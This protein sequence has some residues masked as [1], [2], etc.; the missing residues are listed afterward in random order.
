MSISAVTECVALD[1]YSK[2]LTER[3]AVMKRTIRVA[4]AALSS[5]I[6]CALGMWIILDRATA[7]AQSTRPVPT[8]EVDRS[9]PKIPNG[10]VLGEAASVA[11]D[12]QD[13]VWLLHR[14]A[15]VPVEQKAK[16]A[17]PV[18][19][20][21]ANGNFVQAWGGPGR[22][23]EWPEEE[24]GI[25]VDYK[26]N[27]W[28]GAASQH[29]HDNQVLKFRRNG[30]FLLQIGHSGQSKGNAD[31]E[32]LNRP[33]D[34]FV[35]PKTNEVFIADGYVNRRVIVFDADTGAFKRM[36]GAFGNQPTDLKTQHGNE[37]QGGAPLLNTTDRGPEQFNTVHAARVSNDGLVY[38]SDRGNR[39]VQVF[40]IEGK[41]L[42]QVFIGPECVAPAC[43]NGHTAASS[44]FSAD[45]EQRY[46]YV[47]NRSQG[48]VMIFDRKT[49]DLL[50][51]FGQLGEAPGQF[52][53]IHHMSSDSKG[54]IYTT[55][56]NDNFARGECCRRF[57]KFV[58]SGVVL[59]Q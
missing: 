17:P 45:A 48:K 1:V 54:N 51:S 59:L 36:W 58:F 42:K 19:E 22:G 11:V 26:G 40:T 41:F 5:I 24:H 46:L 56:V 35:Y 4:L 12:A 23:Y 25:F 55:E 27:V 39:R 52:K 14:P 7:Q 16:A 2:S 47:A 18:V 13:H 30:K 6:V 31:T 44:A 10:W 29:G 50:G 34:A 53:V 57:Q 8:F 9:W 38:V 43:G 49:L 28:I 3:K 37:T 33:A 15:T 32:N 21:D 20:L